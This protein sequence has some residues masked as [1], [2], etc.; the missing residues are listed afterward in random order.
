MSRHCPKGCA[1]GSTVFSA[2]QTRTSVRRRR[3]CRKCGQAFT[4]HET[5]EAPAKIT[6]RLI[7]EVYRKMFEEN[8]DA[9]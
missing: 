2:E 1:A 6:E 3:I 5:Y 9:S 7:S 4:T 8:S